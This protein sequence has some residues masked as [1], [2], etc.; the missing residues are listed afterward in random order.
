MLI[1]TKSFR[2]KVKIHIQTSHLY[3]RNI[4]KMF[5][6]K[7]RQDLDTIGLFLHNYQEKIPGMDSPVSDIP[8]S[9][10]RSGRV[11]LA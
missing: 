8:R 5:M 10:P 1:A 2:L 9:V 6:V 11:C 4:R 7:N 3:N